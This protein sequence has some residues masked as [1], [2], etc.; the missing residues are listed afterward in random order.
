[1]KAVKECYPCL[2]RLVH[3]AAGLATSDEKLRA[4]AISEGLRLVDEYFSADVTTITIATEIHRIV[5]G[6]TAN[7]DPYRGVKDE[8]IRISRK[9][10]GEVSPA[11]PRDFKGC[12]S[13][14]AVGNVIDFFR[15][16][17]TIMRDMREKVE[18]LLDD[19]DRF[20]R[21]L[22]KSTN[23]LFLADNAGEVF[24][25]LP[26]TKWMARAARVTYVVKGSPV[27]DDTTL[28]DL[29]IAGVEGEL[30]RVVTTGTATPGVQLHLASHEFKREF[31]AADLI[32]AKGMGYYEGLTEL[33]PD[34]RVLHCLM[35]KCQPVA[36]SIGVPLNSY[37][38][39]LR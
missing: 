3:Q 2:V 6:I 24:F 4:E 29:R 36:D 9:L 35:A 10:I 8:E 28:H 7:P 32:L 30:D 12:L 26:L 5:K 27:Q 31:A 20:E 1:M 14:S 34:G 16:S 23:V 38:A 17:N 15:D 21:M 33:P 11:Y 19:S 39:M 25:D 13:L 22:K 37:V 18:F